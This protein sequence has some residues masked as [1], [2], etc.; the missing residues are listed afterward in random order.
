MVCLH[1]SDLFFFKL[2]GVGITIR[3]KPLSFS[4]PWKTTYLLKE[5]MI[6]CNLPQLGCHSNYNG[7]SLTSM[8][9]YAFVIYVFAKWSQFLSPPGLL[10]CTHVFIFSMFCEWTFNCHPALLKSVRVCSGELG[11]SSKAIQVDSAMAAALLAPDNSSLK[12]EQ[13]TALTILL[14]F[15]MMDMM[16]TIFS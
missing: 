1:W 8:N 16:F 2:C 3:P 9:S 4:P 11:S 5:M 10:H 14:F 13:G 6:F 12:K 15:L 7:S